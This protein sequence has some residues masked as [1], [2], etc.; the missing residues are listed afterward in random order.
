MITC[1][2]AAERTLMPFL[3]NMN[4]IKPCRYGVLRFHACRAAWPYIFEFRNFFVGFDRAGPVRLRKPSRDS[5]R[6]AGLDTGDIRCVLVRADP[7]NV[8]HKIII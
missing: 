1:T 2:N 7:S 5:C 3:K 8:L 4:N 6:D